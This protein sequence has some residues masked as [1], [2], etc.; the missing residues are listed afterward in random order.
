MFLQKP[1]RS[2]ERVLLIGGLG[3][4]GS[5][6]AELLYNEGHD[7]HILSSSCTHAF[8]HINYKQLALPLSDTEGVLLYARNACISVVVHLA[9]RMKP[10]SD[11]SDFQIEYSRI[12]EPSLRLFCGLAKL[13]IPIIYYSSGGTVYGLSHE[14]VLK[15]SF[16]CKPINLY[17]HVKLIYERQLR[18]LAQSSSLRY[19]ILRPSNPY[20]PTQRVS[21]KQGF[22]SA[23]FNSLLTGSTL[24]IWGRGDAVRDYIYINDVSSAVCALINRGKWNATFNLSTGVGYSLLDI[25]TLVENLASTKLNVEYLPSRSVDVPRA[26]LD[27][28]MLRSAIPFSPLD[29]E[30]G[31]MT[32]L[33]SLI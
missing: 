2:K 27:N 18:D 16:L 17:G 25:I 33:Q 4:L 12:V 1:L 32:M 22:I 6:L 21:G 3:F 26:V 31:L 23:V 28:T 24:Q 10:S 9:S 20:G 13:S 30:H 19:L 8:A 5:S 15:E 11:Y 7:V 29:L 14:R